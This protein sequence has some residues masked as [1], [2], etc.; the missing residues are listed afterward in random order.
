MGKRPGVFRVLEFSLLVLYD[1]DVNSSS[2]QKKKVKKDSNGP[3]TLLS[4]T[5]ASNIYSF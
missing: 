3:G 4:T 1:D 5:Y 2:S